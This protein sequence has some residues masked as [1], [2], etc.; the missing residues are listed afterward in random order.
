MKSYLISDNRD[1]Q[2]GLRLAGIEGAYVQDLDNAKSVFFQALNNNYGII[3]LTE[4][5]Y[6]AIKEDVIFHKEKSSLPL[7]T[8]IPDRHG[9]DNNK[10]KITDYIKESIGL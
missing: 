1:T 4:K 3:F 10:D 2:V 8:V 5:I 9:Y 7:I 6:H